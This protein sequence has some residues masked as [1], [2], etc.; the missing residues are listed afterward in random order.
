MNFLQRTPFFRLLL[1]LTAGIVFSQ[2]TALNNICLWVIFLIAPCLFITSFL[3]K[4]NAIR[5]FRWLFGFSASVFVFVLG[6]ALSQ[7][8][9]QHSV[10]P[11]TENPEF[12][13]IEITD[14]PIEKEKSF[15]CKAIANQLFTDTGTIEIHK[16]V[17]L[18]FEKSERAAALNL[19]DLI[20]CQ[21]KFQKPDGQ[22]NPNGFNYAEY[23]ARQ[24]IGATAYLADY[25]W[26]T[27]GR[28]TNFSLPYF[29]KHLQ[30]NLLNV[31]RKFG[32]EGD[33][34]AV[35]AALTLGSTD[36]LHP[37][38]RQFYSVS[39]GMHILSVSGLHVGIIYMVLSFLLSFLKRRPVI[40]A[41]FIVLLL[42]CY[43]LITGLP[44]SVVRSALMF[45]L[46]AIGEGIS[47]KPQIYNT[48]SFSAFVML[49]INPNF[50]FDVG[51]QLS[52]SA[53]VAIVYVQPK[54]A[55]MLYIKNK[56]LR[57]AWDLTAVSLAAQLGTAPLSIYYFHQF[58]NHFLLTNLVAIPIST[59]IIYVAVGLFIVSAIPYLSVAVAFALNMMLKLLNFSLETICNFPFSLSITCFN[60]EQTLM[61][62]AAVILFLIYLA[63]KKFLAIFSASMF[64]FLFFVINIFININTLRSTKMIVYA[65]RKNTSIDF[66]VGKNH[67]VATA[68]E[69]SLERIAESFWLNQKLA[70]YTPASD[71][72]WY[73]D[74]A[75]DFNGKRILVLKNND[76][77]RRVKADIPLQVDFLIVGNNAKPNAERLL[78]NIDVQTVIVDLTVSEFYEN[79]LRATC[80]AK[81][82]DFYSI[83]EN[84]AFVYNF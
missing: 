50:L 57:W 34:F 15:L 74:E 21:A 83:K 73:S 4:N 75:I 10:F 58:P 67:F 26:K 79:S 7:N 27:N 46:V 19:G 70:K 47:R 76:F 16:K 14:L 38:L 63:N 59:L 49:L 8:T 51:F 43:S 53:V 23:L 66:V 2:F 84:G 24:G 30:Q 28:N 11:L 54:I 12:Y 82:I 45:S 36:A 77:V 72:T 29:A 18:Y 6:V 65:D 9:A 41:L 20:V 60:F 17:L 71:E 39:G 33:E 81:G 64:V 48:V 78:Q 5:R 61:L 31:Y 62:Y 42:W 35:L 25:K 55:K 1:A 3:L 69:E 32:I 40:K 44:A 22:I 68:D 52:Y 37:E 56:M 80:A 13:E